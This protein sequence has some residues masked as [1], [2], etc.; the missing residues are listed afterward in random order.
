MGAQ[1][2]PLNK[3]Q[4]NAAQKNAV[5]QANIALVKSIQELQAQANKVGLKVNVQQTV[6]SIQAQNQDKVAEIVK[7]YQ[8]EA[9]SKQHEL[10]TKYIKEISQAKKS[11]FKSVQAQLNKLANQNIQNVPNQEVRNL[12]GELTK[13][14]NGQ[15]NAGFKKAGINANAKIGN[16]AIKNYNQKVQPKISGQVKK[17]QNK[18]NSLNQQW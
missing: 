7:K 16:T 2:A 1:K 15:I 4:I 13:I 18:L 11:S 17:A 3:Q 8:A 6:N 10:Q 9:Q 14:A 12:L 5:K